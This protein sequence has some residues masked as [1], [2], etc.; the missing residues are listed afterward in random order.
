MNAIPIPS[1]IVAAAVLAASLLVAP[2]AARAQ[3]TGAEGTSVA[4]ALF[5]RAKELM[6]ERKYDEACAKFEEV[7]RLEPKAIGTQLQLAD[8]YERAERLASAW[9]TY[10]LAGAAASAAGQRDRVEQARQRAEALKPRV[11]ELTISVPDEVRKLPGLT[12]TRNGVAVGSAQWG[13]AVPVDPG[14]HAIAVSA[15]RKVA[16]E[17]K[18]TLAVGARGIVV[19]VP[20]L[21]DAPA[22]VSN[23]APPSGAPPAADAPG[24]GARAGVPT[25]AWVAGGAGIALTAVGVIFTVDRFRAACDE[26]AQ[27]KCDAR[28]YAP[29]AVDDL[30]G[31]RDRDLGLAIGFGAAGVG[32]LAAAAYGIASASSDKPAAT[33]GLTA[34]PWVSARAAGAMLAGGF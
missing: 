26:D 22:D 29:S 17:E 18:V 23:D 3:S 33:T 19:A 30:N 5:K 14:A 13:L 32:A 7:L 12:I 15:T 11:P 2:P 16:W 8:C 1:R 9:T 6:A 20:A 28:T 4:L 25:W 24:D 21:A 34:T 10:T 31:R 27:G